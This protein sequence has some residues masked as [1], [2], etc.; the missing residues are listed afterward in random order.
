M[1]AARRFLN[2]SP[3][4]RGFGGSG[5]QA[6]YTFMVV[7]AVLPLRNSTASPVNPLAIL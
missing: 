1:V 4:F 2:L 6:C 5:R 3:T 7:L